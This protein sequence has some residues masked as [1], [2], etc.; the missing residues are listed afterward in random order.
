MMGQDD[1]IR[2]LDARVCQPPSIRDADADGVPDDQDRCPRTPYGAPVDDQGCWVAAYPA[3]FDA[4]RAEVKSRYVPYVLD[5][6]R[7][8]KD[9]PDLAVE[10]R[11]CAEAADSGKDGLA[12]ARR[13]AEAV[14]RILTDNGIDADRL[15]LTSRG[16]SEPAGAE[17]GGRAQG[18]RRVEIHVAP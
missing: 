12:L 4:G 8:L 3:F 14:A 9:H 10:I 11:G 15:R 5:A 1:L 16:D 7:I 17:A 2:L 6:A 13:R 18:R